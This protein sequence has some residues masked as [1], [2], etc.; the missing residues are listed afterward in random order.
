MQAIRF[1]D[2]EPHTDDTFGGEKL[3]TKTFCGKINNRKRT[4][5]ELS[6][7]DGKLL[8]QGPGTLSNDFVLNESSISLSKILD[9]VQ[10]PLQLRLHLAYFLAK[11]FWQFYDSSWM[12]AAW[13]KHSIHFMLSRRSADSGGIFI[14][15]PFLSTTLEGSHDLAQVDEEFRAHPLPKLLSLG[16]MLLEIELG[17]KIEDHRMA[18]HLND[19]KVDVNTD[20]SVAA[21]ML[22][23]GRQ[24]A[25]RGTFSK[26]KAVIHS[27]LF[28]K[29]FQGHQNDPKDVRDKVRKNIVNRLQKAYTDAWEDPDTAD[30]R[31]I[32]LHSPSPFSSS[33]PQCDPQWTDG[34]QPSQPDQRK[35]IIMVNPTFQL[36]YLT[37]HQPG[38][39]NGSP[40]SHP[41]Q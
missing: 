20:H 27:C 11:A 37:Q 6:V 25:E 19:G 5:L 7:S 16:I 31:E 34:G 26:F 28:P 41:I 38:Q 13:T 35:N 17:L 30:S 4:Q 36:P 23:L 10:L 8:F 32:K 18:K 21:E 33:R 40:P 15:D 9:T 2:N 24:W 12:H 29:D 1:S 39:I 14:R 22:D 3:S